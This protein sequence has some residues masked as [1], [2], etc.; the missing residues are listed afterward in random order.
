M[1]G[2][3]GGQPPR[4]SSR[5]ASPCCGKSAG[6][7][8]GTRVKRSTSGSE[9]MAATAPRWASLSGSSRTG[10]IGEGGGVTPG[11]D[12]KAERFRALHEGEA[13]IIP[14][15]WDAGAARILE[16]LG[17]QALATTSSGFAFTLGRPDGG[18]TLDD[19]VEHVRTLAAATTLPVSVDLENGYGPDPADAA[20]AIA[21]VA[22]AGAV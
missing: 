17:F 8:S 10:S 13:F 6:V 20:N 18:A 19:V 5:V 11:Q 15:P 7:G 14:N 3:C 4:A 1:A 21:R 16:R 22:D 12:E 2:P 9:S